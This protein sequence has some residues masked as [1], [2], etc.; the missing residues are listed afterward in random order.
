MGGGEGGGN[1]LAVVVVA[2]PKDDPKESVAAVVVVKL[3]LNGNR[4]ANASLT[5]AGSSSVGAV[6]ADVP[7]MLPPFNS[8]VEFGSKEEDEED[9]A[10]AAA[11]AAFGDAP[12]EFARLCDDG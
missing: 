10:E 8:A 4:D 9:D 1:C 3:L 2:E 11:A 5:T 6:D 7:M 12:F